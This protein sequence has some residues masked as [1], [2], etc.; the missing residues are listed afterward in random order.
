MPT[1]NPRINVTFEEK[2]AGLL[3]NL[4]LQEQKSISSLVRELT[5]EAL[6]LREDYHLSK[7]AEQRDSTPLSLLS[8]EDVWK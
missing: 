4:A 3:A 8:H 6:D 5:L 1:K 2:T 7:I